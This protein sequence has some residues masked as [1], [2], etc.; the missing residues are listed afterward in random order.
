[1]SHRTF[2]NGWRPVTFRCGHTS[3]IRKKTLYRA[4]A[5]GR[6]HKLK[7]SCLACKADRREA[8]AT[9]REANR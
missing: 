7:S 1:M 5:N 3:M 9:K 2:A 6:L 4:S 8:T